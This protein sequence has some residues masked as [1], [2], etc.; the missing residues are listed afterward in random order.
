MLA[1]DI[2]PEGVDVGPPQF[3]P[4]A[5]AYGYAYRTVDS[6]ASLE[7]ALREFGA[8]RQVVLIEVRAEA[9]E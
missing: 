6:L 3:E 9:F 7:A 8:R 1:V 4:L 2:E 5:R